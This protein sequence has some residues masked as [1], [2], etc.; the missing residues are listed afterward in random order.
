MATSKQVKRFW[1]YRLKN[2]NFYKCHGQGSWSV[3]LNGVSA[4]AIQTKELVKAQIFR[5]PMDTEPYYHPCMRGGEWVQVERVTTMEI[6][7]SD[8]EDNKYGSKN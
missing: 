2:G 7:V 3:S 1:V 4:K 5:E 6:L 8:Q